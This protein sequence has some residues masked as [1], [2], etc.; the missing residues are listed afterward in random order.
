MSVVDPALSAPPM[1]SVVMTTFNGAKLIGESIQ[2]ILAQT[3]TDFEFI[4]VDDCSTDETVARILAFDDPRIV[5][6]QNN[7][8]LDIVLTRN[9]G[10]SRA[11]GRYIA[12]LDHDD[13]SQ[14]ERL[15]R[16]VAYLEANSA[17]VVLGTVYHYFGSVADREAD[18]VPRHP[19]TIRWMLYCRN[20]I[21]WSSM[22]A[23]SEA[24]RR[25]AGPLRPER[26][27]ADELDF[28]HRMLPLGDVA[29]LTEPLTLYRVHA[30]NTTFSRLREMQ[31]NGT[32]VLA[33]AYAS[34]LGERAEEAADRMVRLVSWREPPKDDADLFKLRT[35]LAELS[36][37]FIRDNAVPADIV[38]EIEAS[39]SRFW[40]VALRSAINSAGLSSLRYIPFLLTDPASRSPE[41]LRALAFSGLP[42]KSALRA[43]GRSLQAIASPNKKRD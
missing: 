31:R 18:E 1:V 29:R 9:L 42:F 30:G 40:S 36:A 10:I 12:M 11:R 34:W 5:L 16:Q 28:Y 27:L 35:D 24:V 41:V 19:L 3:W 2:S 14:P 17:T 20:T 39:V 6:V 38:P 22:M 43:L 32:M 23:R 33:A 21:A 13:L 26:V 4:I 37:N 8:N 25:I 7:R 15:E